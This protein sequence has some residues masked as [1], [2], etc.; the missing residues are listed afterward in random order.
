MTHRLKKLAILLTSAAAAV[1]WG[2]ARLIDRQR[3]NSSNDDN[4]IKLSPKLVDS[5]QNSIDTNNS[6]YIPIESTDAV[7]TAI[8]H[9]ALQYIKQ[10]HSTNVHIREHGLSH[11]AKLKSLPAI[12]YSIIGQQLDYQSA[13][14]LARTYEAHSNLFP[15]GPPYI[16][17]V[18]NQKILSTGNVEKVNDDDV[19]L[20]TIR[21]FLDQL[22]DEKQRPLDVISQHYLKLV[23]IIEQMYFNLMKPI[24][25]TSL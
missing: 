15:I 7:T 19:L 6:I 25:A 13:I 18:G 5:K 1:T 2:I 3:R 24:N 8:Y 23:R 10:T 11:L 9:Q 14:Q 16:F 17:S 4:T 22:I 12:Y 21:K 20:H